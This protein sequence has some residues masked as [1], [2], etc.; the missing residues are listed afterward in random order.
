MRY[1]KIDEDRENLIGEIN[2]YKAYKKISKG[3]LYASVAGL[4][5]SAINFYFSGEPSL[6][7]LN[8]S[9]NQMNKT[10]LMG[11]EI[12]GISSMGYFAGGFF[13]AFFEGLETSLKN[14]L[15]EK[16]KDLEKTLKY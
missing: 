13:Y 6:Q 3:I 11:A 14:K 16:K 7:T 12:F 4:A 10:Q 1:K 5:I 2:H 8:E 15:K 9:L